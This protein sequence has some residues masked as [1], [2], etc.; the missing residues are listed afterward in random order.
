[1]VPYPFWPSGLI[2]C[3]SMH[4][5]SPDVSRRH[6]LCCSSSSIEDRVRGGYRA[7]GHGCV[8]PGLAENSEPSI[9]RQQFPHPSLCQG[10]QETGGDRR[11]DRAVP[12]GQSIG[13]NGLPLHRAHGGTPMVSM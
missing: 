1:M 7:L 10:E 12:R 8:S 9:E 11:G 5:P 2:G 3:C 6:R 13:T 4:C